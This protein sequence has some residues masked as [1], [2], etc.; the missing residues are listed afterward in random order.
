V[1]TNRILIVDDEDDIRALMQSALERRGFEVVAVSSGAE[2]I[3]YL[4]RDTPSIICL[5]LEMDDGS[6]WT[7]LSAL[8]KH[9]GFRSMK[10]V[11]VSGL[12]A[13][14]PSWAGFIRKP[15][16]IDA[17]LE[18]VGMATPA[19]VRLKSSAG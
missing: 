12:Q 14:V 6:G 7:V 16:R 2:A 8:P 1:R 9:P 11:V 17:F 3:A 10:V 4:A 19:P 18:H 5:D 13:T 15:F